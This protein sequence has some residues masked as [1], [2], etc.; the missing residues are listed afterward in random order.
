MKPA[1]IVLDIEGTI[2]PISFVRDVLFPYARAHLVEFLSGHGTDPDVAAEI[3]AVQRLAPGIDV[4]GALIGWMDQDLKL[5]PLKAIQGM[6]WRAGYDAGEI[7]GE[8]YEDVAPC[9]RDWR[10]QGIAL[11]IYSSG[12]VAAQQLLLAHTASG[13]LRP[14]IQGYFDTL[15]GPKR[16]AVSYRAI[17]ARIGAAPGEI[18][19]LSDV[20][21][22]LDTADAAG[23]RTVQVVREAD[24]TVASKR[25]Q[26]SRTLAELSLVKKTAP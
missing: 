6:I 15:M 18:L 24:G 11:Y 10:N 25:H 7:K 4:A 16:E 12:S 8:L 20:E 23:W 5:P 26:S 3:A 9:L 19:F 2:A 22:E 13:D 1:A 21:A 17:A 14:L